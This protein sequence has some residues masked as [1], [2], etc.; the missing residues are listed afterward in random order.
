MKLGYDIF[1]QVDENRL[2]W[3]DSAHELQEARSRILSLESASP[4]TC[5]IYDAKGRVVLE[6][7]GELRLTPGAAS[8]EKESALEAEAN[9]RG[10]L[11]S[12]IRGYKRRLA[13]L[14][15]KWREFIC[16]MGEEETRIQ[17]EDA[18]RRVQR[19]R[20]ERPHP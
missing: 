15:H 10:I 18:L 1:Q 12:L 16:V 17:C 2:V 9:H 6:A 7:P 14:N 20:N 4:G 5:L 3:V 11:G 13:G 8:A 19:T